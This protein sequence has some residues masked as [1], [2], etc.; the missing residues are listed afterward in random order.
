MNAI[1]ISLLIIVSA[2]VNANQ[3]EIRYEGVGA[4]IFANLLLEGVSRNMTHVNPR[5]NSFSA[6]NLTFNRKNLE[7]SFDRRMLQCPPNFMCAMVMP[8]PIKI[9]LTI[10]KIENTDCSI[11]YTAHTPAGIES[12]IYEEVV[13]EDFTFSKCA[14]SLQLPK[15]AGAVSY[16]VT[17]ISS[18]TKMQETATAH[19]SVAKFVRAVN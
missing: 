16:K 12:N 1:L 8:P 14:E 2:S 5:M 4:P 15:R 7:L 13:V 18:L 19:F 6:A 3:Q 9:K 10:S 17:G 11:I